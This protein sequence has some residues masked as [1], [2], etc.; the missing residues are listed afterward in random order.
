MSSCE[1][2]GVGTRVGMGMGVNASVRVWV[3]SVS[4]GEWKKF[5]RAMSY[6]QLE[7]LCCRR[8]RK[9]DGRSVVVKFFRRGVAM[10]LWISFWISSW[11]FRIAKSW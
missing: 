4:D 9:D 2:V 6:Y 8:V 5:K 1:C 3:M 7:V 10:A 11:G